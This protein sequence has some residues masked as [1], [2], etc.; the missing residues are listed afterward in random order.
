MDNTTPVV[1]LE[2]KATLREVSASVTTTMLKSVYFASYLVSLLTFSSFPFSSLNPPVLVPASSA[3]TIPL[4][5]P[6]TRVRI[7]SMRCSTSNYLFACV[8]ESG[9]P[10]VIPGNYFNCG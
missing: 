4:I 5:V 2:A 3:A 8:D 7:L 1:V 9:C 10:T 6:P